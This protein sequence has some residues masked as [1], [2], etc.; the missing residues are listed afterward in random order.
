MWFT[1]SWLPRVSLPLAVVGFTQE[2]TKEERKGRKRRSGRQSMGR[3][4]K[5][6]QAG[7]E[8]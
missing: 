1:Q 5:Q 2:L 7:S 6:T 8:V 3:L 4:R